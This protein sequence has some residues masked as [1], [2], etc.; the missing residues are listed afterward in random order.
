M[1][2]DR[3]P[4]SLWCPA[5]APMPSGEPLDP[6]PDRVLDLIRYAES[7]GL[8]L[9]G[10]RLA[11]RPRPS[12]VP[13]PSRARK[14]LKH[15][16]RQDKLRCVSLAKPAAPGRNSLANPSPEPAKTAPAMRVRRGRPKT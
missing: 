13:F 16:R 15:A 4:S 8:Q 10:V 12:S 1:S 6:L 14:V 11:F 5:F 3:D 9:A 2:T 7:R